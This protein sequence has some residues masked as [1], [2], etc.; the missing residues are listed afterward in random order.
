MATRKAGSKK[1]KTPAGRRIKRRIVWW[2]LRAVSVVFMLA[3]A[4]TVL[5]AVFNPPTTAYMFSEGR[6]L[7]GVEHRWVAMADIAPVM[8]RSAVAA[9]DANFCHHW[10]FDL[11]A[12]KLAI[13]QGSARGAST[14][15]QQ[16]VKNV[17]LWQGRSWLRKAMEAMMTPVVELIWSKRR[18]VEVYLNVAEFDEGVFGVDAAARH[19]FGVTAADLSATQAAR[20]AAILPAPKDRSAANPS[21]FVRKRTAQIRDGAA[22]IRADG[23]AACFES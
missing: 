5:W 2:L 4:L 1:T 20:L 9:E 15:S 8:A 12:I 11:R 13:E 16:V 6:R 22:T 10:G 23:R 18:I 7:G 19:Y 17:Y 3:V 14:I 21:N